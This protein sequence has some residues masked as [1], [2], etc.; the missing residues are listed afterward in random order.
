VANHVAL[1]DLN[2]KEYSFYMLLFKLMLSYHG[3]DAR[4]FGLR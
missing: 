1:N 3:E 2:L 4:L